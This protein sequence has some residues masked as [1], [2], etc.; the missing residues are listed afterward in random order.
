VIEHPV[1][2]ETGATEEPRL[3]VLPYCNSAVVAPRYVGGHTQTGIPGEPAAGVATVA[4]VT[5]SVAPDV[6]L[7]AVL[8]EVDGVRPRAM[9]RTVA[10]PAGTLIGDCP[11]GVTVHGSEG[12]ERASMK[13][14][15][16]GPCIDCEMLTVPVGTGVTVRSIC[17][18][19][20]FTP[21]ADAV[22]N[23]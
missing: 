1:A 16:V 20:P 11:L 13:I 14:T 4:K 23:P 21:V 12:S 18:E 7:T 15:S 22:M 6:Q 5:V 3:V 8:Y 9:P 17:V 10:S 2:Q 19:P